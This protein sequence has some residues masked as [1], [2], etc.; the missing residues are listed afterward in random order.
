MMMAMTGVNVRRSGNSSKVVRDKASMRILQLE[1]SRNAS[2]RVSNAAL[3]G[4]QFAVVPK[5]VTTALGCHRGEVNRAQYLTISVLDRHA[6]S[7][8]DCPCVR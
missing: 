6:P 7:S 3:M 4:S 1:A 2:V 5:F 8:A